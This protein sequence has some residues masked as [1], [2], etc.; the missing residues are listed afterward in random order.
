MGVCC[1]HKCFVSEPRVSRAQPRQAL[2]QQ[3]QGAFAVH[4]Y[5]DC[6]GADFDFAVVV[7]ECVIQ[8]PRP[9]VRIPR[10]FGCQK[11]IKVVREDG[12]SVICANC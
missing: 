4:L 7:D 2:T 10:Q 9:E 8:R 6:I 3:R 12:N 1:K 11:P 5:H